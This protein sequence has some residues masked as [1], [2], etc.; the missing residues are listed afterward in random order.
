[1]NC[2]S[3]ASLWGG[4]PKTTTTMKKYITPNTET[5]ETLQCF[6]L[7]DPSAGKGSATEP[8]PGGGSNSAPN[9]PVF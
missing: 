1:M 6:N 4:I 2:F 8:V 3:D 7:C 5:L 9:R